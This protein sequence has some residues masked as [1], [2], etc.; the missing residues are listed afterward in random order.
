MTFGKAGTMDM[1]RK[2]DDSERLPDLWIGCTIECFQDAGYSQVVIQVLMMCR[3]TWPMTSKQSFKIRV[4]IP[5]E[6]Q[7]PEFFIEKRT[8]RRKS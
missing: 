4:Q 8:E 5:S 3:K 1:G 6:P 2:F 7:A